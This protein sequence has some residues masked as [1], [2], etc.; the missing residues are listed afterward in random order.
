MSSM[1]SEMQTEIVTTRLS[2]TSKEQLMV[3]SSCEIDLIMLALLGSDFFPTFILV[4][5]C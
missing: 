5:C 4:V 1:K 2:R 3:M